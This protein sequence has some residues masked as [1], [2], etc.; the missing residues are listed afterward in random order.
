MLHSLA[1]PILCQA[2]SEI[3]H[4]VTRVPVPG[5]VAGIGLLLARCLRQRLTGGPLPAADMLRSHLSVFFVPPG[6][7]ALMTARRFAHIA[8]GLAA[9]LPGSAGLAMVVT[10]QVVQALLGWSERRRAQ[11]GARR[12]S[13]L[14]TALPTLRAL[15]P[16]AATLLAF[17]A[18]LWAQRRFRGAALANPVLIAPVLIAVLLMW[19]ALTATDVSPPDHRDGVAPISLLLGSATVAPA[20]PLLRSLA[21]IREGPDPTLST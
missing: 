5:T 17:E 11:R 15:L 7:A 3:M 4:A 9:G 19:A 16:L 18:G 13:V 21:R 1:L 20:I 10:G 14:V 8:P 6:V 2:A 12:W